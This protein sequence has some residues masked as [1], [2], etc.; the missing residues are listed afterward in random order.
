MGT[1]LIIKMAIAFQVGESTLHIVYFRK[2]EQ[3]FF[4]VEYG[5]SINIKVKHQKM[6]F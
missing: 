2:M 5:Y 3:L 6:R 4:I 1:I